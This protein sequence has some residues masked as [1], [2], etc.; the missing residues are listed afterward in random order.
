MLV[1]DDEDLAVDQLKPAG[2]EDDR[3][4]ASHRSVAGAIPQEVAATRSESID[5]AP[6]LNLLI[7]LREQIGRLRVVLE[8]LPTKP[9][10]R[11]DELD[12]KQSDLTAQ[13]AEHM[14]QLAD[15]EPP[16]RRLGRIRDPH[17][18]SRAFLRTAIEQD[19]RALSDLRADRVR[20]QRELGD[21]DHVRSERDGIENAI[22]R[23]EREHDR[24]LDVLADRIIERR[25]EWLT[26]SLGDRPAGDREGETWD[27]AARG[28]ASYRLEHDVV[29][30]TAVLG[31]PPSDRDAHHRHWEQAAAALERAQRQLGW[32]PTERDRGL[33]LGIG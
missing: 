19:D 12:V 32:E 16:A 4:L 3:S 14:S 26:D 15:L 27:R 11:F 8:A 22:T 10:A 25:P 24:L 17:A 2:R 29:D 13:R 20:L 9:L 30:Q 1:R 33:D 31:P 28:V 7:E 6:S 21:P 18:E 5:P 23:L